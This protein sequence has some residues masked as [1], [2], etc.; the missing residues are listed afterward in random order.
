MP[1]LKIACPDCGDEYQTLVVEGARI[2]TVWVCAKCKRRNG[3][4]VE[5]LKDDNGHPWA[6]PS[7]DTCCN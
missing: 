2:P 5:I 4:V 7:M 1:L 6:G 3:R